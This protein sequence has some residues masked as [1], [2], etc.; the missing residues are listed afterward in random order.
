MAVE[1]LTALAQRTALYWLPR[2]FAA[3]ERADLR[4]GR[5]LPAGHRRR[6]LLGG[7]LVMWALGVLAM[8][9]Y[10]E[11][12]FM[13]SAHYLMRVINEGTF[14]VE[15]NRFVLV[16]AEWPGLLASR[17]GL[18]MKTVLMAHSVGNWLNFYLLFL[19]LAHARRE[20]WAA[21]AIVATQALG[22]AQGFYC[23]IFEYYYGFAL[24]VVFY[25]LW[26]RQYAFR[27]HVALG[28]GL[29]L[30]LALSAHLNAF[31]VLAFILLLTYHPERHWGYYAAFIAV[32]A[33]HAVFKALFATEYEQMQAGFIREIYT[34]KFVGKVF[35]P[36]YVLEVL[37]YAG[38]H[39]ADVLLVSGLGVGLLWRVRDTGSRLLGLFLLGAY[40]L[41][42]TYHPGTNPSRYREQVNYLATGLVGFWVLCVAVPVL[43][44]AQRRML[45]AAVFAVLA[46]RVGYI[47]HTGNTV[48]APRVQRIH[49][50]IACATRAHLQKCV[51]EY[52]DRTASHDDDNLF[53]W[54]LG[55]ESL[56]LSA[57]DGPATAVQCLTMDDAVH[58]QLSD[59]FTAFA[60]R[61][62]E[63][64]P[65]ATYLN[66]EY[67]Q[68][69]DSTP[70]QALACP[71]AA[72]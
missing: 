60:F 56:M 41:I 5:L 3:P 1:K 67:F 70:Y 48:F 30:A 23:P 33:A 52:P 55:Q 39:Y 44:A 11:R 13:D 54:S 46:V 37:A 26:H 2:T 15:H 7:H 10:E 59:T 65:S 35:K 32:L 63:V 47:A 62:W 43:P 66:P 42:N 68:L 9:F 38:V 40:I 49:A 36:S 20:V 6:L 18:S 72:P 71:E 4:S 27:W 12:I 24:L 51:A 14:W 19:F 28:L 61:R 16:L 21:L 8:V 53:Q 17:L 64:Y 69:P 57:Q 34:F 50:L 29:L 22:M 25:A 45:V 58:L 31:V